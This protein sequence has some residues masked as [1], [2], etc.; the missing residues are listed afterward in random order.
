MTL[1]DKTVTAKELASALNYAPD[2][3][4]RIVPDLVANHGMP[5]RLPSSRRE[6]RWSRPAVENWLAT[7]HD[8]AGSRVILSGPDVPADIAD[9]RHALHLAYAA[10]AEGARA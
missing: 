8:A 5:C 10:P 1:M 3:F 9:I 4:L 2:Y 6:F 7:Y